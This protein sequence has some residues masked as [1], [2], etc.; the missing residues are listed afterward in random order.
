MPVIA[1][2]VTYAAIAQLY[3]SS[4][5]ENDLIFINGLVSVIRQDI[6][7]NNKTEN[8]R[9]TIRLLSNDNNFFLPTRKIVMI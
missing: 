7:R 9:I 3:T 4:L 5:L 8:L 2:L 6:P 1:F